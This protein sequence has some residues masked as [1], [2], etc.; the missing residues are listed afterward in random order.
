MALHC[1]K[2]IKL[3]ETLY[4]SW[5]SLSMLN[6]IE[7]HCVSIVYVFPLSVLITTDLFLLC[8]ITFSTTPMVPL[9]KPSDTLIFFVTITTSP[10]FMLIS[11][12]S[13][14]NSFILFCIFSPNILVLN[15]TGTILSISL[16]FQLIVTLL[17]ISIVGLLFKSKY[18]LFILQTF[19]FFADMYTAL[20]SST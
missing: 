2:G 9:H 13:L 11:L 7:S 3:T 6:L 15:G 14:R 12:Y 19:S 16:S 17:P 18:L 4:I 10:F 20:F 1:I 8:S 5:F